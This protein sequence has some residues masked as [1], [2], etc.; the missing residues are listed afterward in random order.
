MTQCITATDWQF[1]YRHIVDSMPL[2]DCSLEGEALNLGLAYASTAWNVDWKT[3]GAL[4]IQ[5]SWMAEGTRYGPSDNCICEFQDGGPSGIAVGFPV[6]HI[7]HVAIVVTAV[8]ENETIETEIIRGVDAIDSGFA[9]TR[10]GF[11]M[12]EEFDDAATAEGFESSATAVTLPI[13][14]DI[15]NAVAVAIAGTIETIGVQ[16]G[17]LT[18]STSD[19]DRVCWEDRRAFIAALGSGFSDSAY[20]PRADFDLD[21]DVDSSDYATYLSVFASMACA[22]DFDCNGAVESPDIFAFLS[23]Y[24]AATL[25]GDFDGDSVVSTPDIFAFLAAFFAG[26]D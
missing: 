25:A 9:R 11:F 8:Y 21:G 19:G 22:A 6:R 26:C 5:V 18:P 1:D 2:E 10:L 12:N 23:A 13:T 17:D 14:I 3:H 24:F 16:N 4:A 15:E 7:S 20:T